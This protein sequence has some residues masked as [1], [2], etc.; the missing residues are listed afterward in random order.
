MRYVKMYYG[1]A[2]SVKKSKYITYKTKVGVQS[3][4]LIML[5]C[6]SLQLCAYKYSCANASCGSVG[7]EPGMVSMRMRV[8]L[9][10]ALLGGLRSPRDHKP[11][12]RSQMQVRSGI[13]VALA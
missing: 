11:C 5:S 13:A 10:L 7:S 8:V 2:N 6:I 3:M 4:F 12:S 9:P 1:R